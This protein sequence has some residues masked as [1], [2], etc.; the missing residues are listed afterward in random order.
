MPF[1]HRWSHELHQRPHWSSILRPNMLVTVERRNYLTKLDSA[2]GTTT[3]TTQVGGPHGWLTATSKAIGYLCQHR[4]LQSIDP[5]DGK[6]LWQKELGREREI[7]GRL[8]VANDYFLVGGWR[9][10]TPLYCLDSNTGIELWHTESANTYALPT[11][12]PW[13]IALIEIASGTLSIVDPQ[14]GKLLANFPLPAGIRESDYHL[15]VQIYGQKLLATTAQ[16]SLLL[17]D[18]FKDQEWQTLG[19]HAAGIFTIQPTILD[20]WLIFKDTAGSLCLYDLAAGRMLWSEAIVH[21]HSQIPAIR[22][23]PKQLIV[24]T[25]EGQLL[26]FDDDG[27]RLTNQM[28]GKRITTI[29]GS[30]QP[31]Q[32]ILGTTGALAC[33]ELAVPPPSG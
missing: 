4:L 7:Y 9:G 17:I 5:N 25:S 22:I 2:N 15:S 24:G 20:D 28:I 29:L 31:Q 14:T 33:Y 23:F 18:P 27:H 1:I 3:W 12:G 32:I 19:T 10:Y 8:T 11:S 21:H 6:L 30:T 26:L 16:G 13:G